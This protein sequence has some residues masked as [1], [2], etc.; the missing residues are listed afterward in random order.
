MNDE[1]QALAARCVAGSHDG[2][3]S[4]PEIVGTLMAAGFDGYFVDYRSGNATYYGADGSAHA[5]ATKRPVT[6][7][8][9]IFDRAAVQAAIR[10]AQSG[11]ADYTYD[12]FGEAVAAAGCV[13]YLVSFPGRRVVYIGRSGETHE[14]LMP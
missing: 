11:A 14:E 12:G 2:T 9:A 8:P 13:S 6:E 1:M 7:A 5:V 4:F 10:H 3:M